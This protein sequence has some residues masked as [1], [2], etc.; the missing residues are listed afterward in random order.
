MKR[1]D[2]VFLDVD[3]LDLGVGFKGLQ[4]AG[5]D[6]VG[7][8]KDQDAGLLRVRRLD[9]LFFMLFVTPLF[10]VGN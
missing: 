2:R 6:E 1:L 8:A 5:E 10:I 9:F 7:R 3:D 4:D